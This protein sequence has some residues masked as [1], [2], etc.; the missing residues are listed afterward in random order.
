MV[1]DLNQDRD[2]SRTYGTHKGRAMLGEAFDAAGLTCHTA[3]DVVAAGLL[4]RHHLID[5]IAASAD[6]TPVAD[7]FCWEP[8]NEDGVRMSDHPGVAVALSR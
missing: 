5:H 3:I 1:A 4:N 7:P 6:L 2:G 8:I